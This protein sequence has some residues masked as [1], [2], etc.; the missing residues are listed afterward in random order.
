MNLFNISTSIISFFGRVSVSVRG[1]SK[2]NQYPTIYSWQ[3]WWSFQYGGPPLPIHDSQPF[4]DNISGT[5]RRTCYAHRKF[6][7]WL[8]SVRMIQYGGC[9]PR[10]NQLSSARGI[11]FKAPDWLPLGTT[12]VIKTRANFEAERATEY[13]VKRILYNVWPSHFNV[14]QIFNL[15]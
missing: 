2:I 13:T 15:K 10:A 1:D 14:S 12:T 4:R 3:L 7:K 11:Q 5:L 6:L 9:R 8:R